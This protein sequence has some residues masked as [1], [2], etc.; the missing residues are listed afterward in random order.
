MKP[1]KILLILVK[2]AFS[3]CLLYLLYR[4]IPIRAIAEVL[5]DIN[6]VYLIPVALLLFVNSLLSAWKWQLF[7]QADEID[8]PF[9]TLLSTYM[10]AYFYN[11]FLPTNIGGDAYRIY[12]V[13]RRSGETVR[14]VASVFADRVTGFVAMVSLGAL[15]SPYVAYRFG[16]PLFFFGPIAVFIA[17]F[18][19][20]YCLYRQTP[21][22]F[23]LRVTGLGK[24]QAVERITEKFFL[25]FARYGSNRD[26]L[27]KT[28]L[29][30][31][32]FQ[33]SVMTI[34]YLL[35][36]SLH[37]QVPYIYFCAFV[38]LIGLM[39]MLPLSINGIGLRDAGYVFFFGKA[40]MSDLQT[41]S[42]AILF[43]AMSIT[44]SLSGGLFY[45]PRLISKHRQA[46]RTSDLA[47]KEPEKS[48]SNDAA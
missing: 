30:S 5:L 28:M 15:A 42:L 8:L 41:R 45:L 12:D 17:L 13:S 22:R 48:E 24:I 25:S 29:I 40:G 47:A 4:K 19:A 7:L 44:Y 14:T 43:L 27:I 33:L 9:F 36:R 31:F 46:A 38:P 32:A 3:A 26:L 20:L 34:I 1:R 16:E 11:M 18:V 35:S 39:E 23:L 21:V 2:L 6:P 37:A 10:I